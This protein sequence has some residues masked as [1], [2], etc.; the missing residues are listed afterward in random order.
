MPADAPWL[1]VG[2]GNPGPKY[3]QNR[4]NV[5]FLAVDRWVE[6]ELPLAPSWS[7]RFSAQCCNVSGSFG[8]VVALKPQ[9]FMNRSGQAVGEASRYFRVPVEQV[10]VIHDELDFPFAKVAIK[11]AGGHGGHNG[12]RDIIAH[13]GS[14]NFSRIRAGIGRPTQGEVAKWVLSDY[15]NSER[16]QLDVQLSS[17]GEALTCILTRGVGPAMNIF[18]QKEPKGTGSSKS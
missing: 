2:L 18:N 17:V 4:H 1:V 16:R 5:G 3:E 12:L 15:S 10:V 11:Q 8:R 6:E 7:E 14:P 9:T 13:L